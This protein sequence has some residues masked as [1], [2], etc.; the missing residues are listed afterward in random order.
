MKDQRFKSFFLSLL[1]CFV[2]ILL[3][4]QAFAQTKEPY[5][6]LSGDGKTYTF[7]Y[8]EHKPDGARPFGRVPGS[9]EKVIFEPSFKDFRPTRTAV[10]FYDCKALKKIDGI[11]Y[12][13][14][15]QVTDMGSMF[16]GCSSLTSL[17]LSQFNT[18]Q[19][20]NMRDMFGGCSSLI[21]LNLANFNT[22]QVTDMGFIFSGCSSLTELNL[23][24]FNTVKV[25]NM[26]YMFNNCSSLSE[27]NISNFNT[28][29]VE[30][31]R[32]MFYNCSSLKK[33]KLHSFNTG[34]VENML[35]MFGGC[36]SLKELNL[37]NF[38]TERVKDMNQMFDG[39]SSLT[40]LNLANFNTSKVKDMSDMF[41]GCKSLTSID[42]SNFNTEKVREMYKMFY[43]C[44][45]LISLNLSKFN[46][47]KVTNMSY[48]FYGCS[49]LISLDLSN[50]NAGQ[51]T[52]TTGM[53]WSC[54]NLQT[55]FCR[56][57]WETTYYPFGNNPKLKG[58]VAYV[59]KK[60]GGDMANPYTGY[61][62]MP[63]KKVEQCDMNDV[64]STSPYYAS[65]SF[66]CE[67]GVLSGAKIDGA[68]K[69][70]DKLTRAQLAKIGFR[71][72]YLTN[73]RKVPSAV[74]SDNF[75]SIYPDISH[76]TADNEY[77]YQA[78]RALMYLEY[79]DGI[80]PF[81]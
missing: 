35:A 22:E 71:G 43:G 19:V 54:S 20:T 70:E 39:C 18:E 41:S 72:L 26:S 15:E 17:N 42:L 10:L 12:L 67:R 29:Q 31:M 37:S 61:F 11:E 79:G 13:N 59:P 21:S 16:G 14:T 34:K 49:S 63:T 23:S 68:V 45:S 52:N 30:D 2:G 51:A 74:P 4:L 28:N 65:T 53:F 81:D 33:L 57:S 36:S 78:A 48:M 47:G 60:S 56:S 66:L 80:S 64:P 5:G 62:T 24:N 6:V 58:A 50:F 76:R 46:T 40:S 75:P 38:N 77:Y 1:F 44:S 27:I 8:D 32:L 7:R 9:V 25:T 73:G 55:I 69:V 3:P